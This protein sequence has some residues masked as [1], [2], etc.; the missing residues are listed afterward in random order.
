MELN[1]FVFTRKFDK[2]TNKII[3]DVVLRN[4][5]AKMI[6]KGLWDTGADFSCISK[7]VATELNLI[8]TRF[9]NIL[10][11]S[12]STV[13]PK[14]TI[15]IDLPEYVTFETMEVCESEIGNQG[16]EMLIGMDV[17]SKGNFSISNFE[18]K[19]VFSYAFPSFKHI[20]F[21][22]NTHDLTVTV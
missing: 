20:D 1:A 8:P 2:I 14:Y 15:T 9:I 3:T 10:T 17:I 13:K 11:P 21:T 22:D 12:G 6:G 16:I 19:T 5:N 18:D 7:K 4:N